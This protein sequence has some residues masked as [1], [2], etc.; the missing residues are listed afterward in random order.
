MS[1]V[2]PIQSKIKDKRSFCRRLGIIYQTKR[3]C[4]PIATQLAYS[5]GKTE[6]RRWGVRGSAATLFDAMTTFVTSK[7]GVTTSVKCRRTSEIDRNIW[8]SMPRETQCDWTVRIV[9]VKT[10]VHSFLLMC[11]ETY[12]KA[13]VLWQ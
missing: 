7:Q 1:T 10:Y 9:I 11:D 2:L 3:V 5:L 4:T 12:L 6:W 13:S 8:N